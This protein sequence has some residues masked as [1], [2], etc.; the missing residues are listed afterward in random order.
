MTAMTSRAS[1]LVLAL[2]CGDALARGA[3][4]YLPL[5]LSAEMDRKIQRVLLLGD[6]P[7]MRRPIA[8]AVV[9]DA[10]PKACQRD[11]AL[12]EEVRG[13]LRRFMHEAGVTHL[14][15]SLAATDGDSGYSLPNG[16][17][18][19]VDSPWEVRGLAYY[20]PSDYVLLSAGGIV[21]DED[22][23]ATDSVI[24]LGFEYAQ[25]DIGFRDHWL[26]P[27]TDSSSTISTQAPTM[28]SVTLSN[29]TPIS[30]VGINY[31]VFM[32]EMSS[33]DGIAVPGGTTSGNPCL[34][35]LQ[36]G[37]EPVDGYSVAVNRITQY[38]GGARGSC[39]SGFFDA[40]FTNSN[41]ADAGQ[42]AENTNRIASLTSSIL[43]PGRVPFAVH[44][45]YAGEDNAYR[46]RSLLGATN[47]SF[48]IDFPRVWR[49]FDFT[50]ETSEWQNDWYT[51]SLYPEGL[52]HRGHVIGHWFGDNRQRG[53]AIGGSSQTVRAGW[54]SSAGRY[55]QATYRTM[56]PDSE[57]R[58]PGIPE[59]DY[60]RV[61]ALSLDMTT[62]W[63]GRP[64]H[65]AL[66]V[67]RDVFGESFARLDASVDFADMR[68][69]AVPG[70]DEPRADDADA[71]VEVFVDVGANYSRVTNILAVDIP[72][73]ATDWATDYYL[74]IGARRRVSERSDLGV[75][76]ELDEVQGYR[77]LS[78][79][80][81]D[82]RFRWHPRFAVSAFFG[83]GRYDVGLAADG[84]Y[85]GVGFQY[86]EILPDWDLSF[87]FRHHE[88]LGRDKTLSTDPPSTPDR[89]R[90]FFDID[91]VALYLS[92]RW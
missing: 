42:E 14:K 83:A 78:I 19:E 41:E 50:F 87:D 4:P 48:G 2:F 35:G 81:L 29:Y 32:A 34:A 21:R 91:G 7:A 79:R 23:I 62:G 9:L 57:W 67:G 27:L 39:S 10:L 13:Y 60:E 92:R 24:S 43:F 75:R 12:C 76:L 3:S 6:K 86:R 84:Y 18:L 69:V 49:N 11:R 51:H 59:V 26:S 66:N 16:H 1:G 53:D 64:V 33:Q 40:L 68:V 85:Y 25:F 56:A 73:Y 30:R 28:P 37:I 63:R 47:L 31:E 44:V 77:L 8:A 88:K 70:P 58:L 82:Y 72:D 65:A 38:G 61:Q 36:A 45:E 71:K 90:L 17:G 55:W 15:L 54:R 80:A 74:G 46:G 20:R 89:T 52:T 22:A 5:N